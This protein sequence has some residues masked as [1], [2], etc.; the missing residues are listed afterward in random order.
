MRHFL[1]FFLLVSLFS[2]NKEE[3]PVNPGPQ[4]TCSSQMISGSLY[5]SNRGGAHA[6]FFSQPTCYSNPDSGLQE[7]VTD[8]SVNGDTLYE[9]VYPWGPPYYPRYEI[10]VGGDY[11]NDVWT[12][13]GAN[14]IPSF[15]FNNPDSFPT[16][17][18][19]L[20]D[21][22][23]LN[24][25]DGLSFNVTISGHTSG[26]LYVG[27]NYDYEFTIQEGV[28]TITLDSAQLATLPSGYMEVFIRS[29]HS[30]FVQ[31]AGLN[32]EVVKTWD[33]YIYQQLY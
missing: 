1:F 22:D 31:I 14:G 5:V 12:V 27:N 26:Y 3:A 11:T 25:N 21:L 6:V 17:T 29:M 10:N 28:N 24:R 32:F 9:I 4:Q 8:V 13:N 2:C 33:E 16:V 7:F 20:I 30:S 15:V 19:T 23:S 18:H